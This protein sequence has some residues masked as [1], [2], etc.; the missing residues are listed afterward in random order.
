M[1]LKTGSFV[2][3]ANDIKCSGSN[4]VVWGAGVVGV[5]TTSEILKQ[6][7][8]DEFVS[9]C[10]DNDSAR[11]GENVQ[12]GRKSVEIQNP[13]I[14]AKMSE[15]TVVLI[16]ISRYFSAL[17]QLK[18]IVKDKNVSCY[19]IP[20]MCIENFRN[21]EFNGAIKTSDAP[22]IPKKIHYMWLGGN[23]LPECLQKCIDSWKE[24]CPDYEI[25]RWDETN[26]D[27]HKNLFMSQAY[28]NGKFGFVP[29]YARLDILYN[30]GGIYM[31]TDVEILRNLDDLLY[32]ES[33]CG[34]EKWQVLNF[35]GCSGAVKGTKVL[36][37][38]LEKWGQRVLLRKDGSLDT[39]SSG[40]IDTTV[41][42]KMG[43]KISGEN[44]MLPGINIYSY[45]YFHPYDYM[46]GL[47]EKTGNTFSIHHFNGG[48]LDEKSKE[49]NIK[50]IENYKEI[51][52]NA[53]VVD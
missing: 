1:I 30:Y 6:Y 41:A 26:Y 47:L 40:L 45:D 32:Q 50:T 43:Y 34:V 13:D 39:I 22:I 8:I 38:F 3:M 11:W 18:N 15:N 36:E 31:D 7:N 48:W 19:I 27:V 24:Y 16:T 9:C 2:G 49:N 44:Q 5:T 17:E 20:V 37:P 12:L 29:D 4:V 23:P 46:S 35:G 52:K 33:F 28:D 21:Q 10:V 14:I 51:L 42:F 25:V 53:I